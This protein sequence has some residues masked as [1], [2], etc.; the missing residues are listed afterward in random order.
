[1]ETDTI[2]MTVEEAEEAY[3]K[4]AELV[5]EREE[6]S[7]EILKQ[8]SYHLSQ[9]RKVLNI[10]DSILRGGV[11]ENKEPKLA[12]GRAD[13]GTVFFTK[14]RGKSGAF[15]SARVGS[16]WGKVDSVRLPINYFD[17]EWEIEDSTKSWS[18]PKRPTIK[19]AI[20]LIPA[21]LMPKGKLNNYYILFEVGRWEEDLSRRRVGDDPL[22]LR[23]LSEN[24]F[25]VLAMWDVSPLEKAVLEGLK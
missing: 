22:L 13:W 17:E 15:G 20:P 25:V 1:M 10:Y 14:H 24:M 19:S 18:E 12:I 8:A 2:D 21:E 7:L 9:G 5:K 23:R 4:Y 11:D 3:K 6:K 16:N